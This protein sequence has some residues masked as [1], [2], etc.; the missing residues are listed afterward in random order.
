MFQA[1][2]FHLPEE[3]HMYRLIVLGAAALPL[4]VQAGLIL[5]APPQPP[6]YQVIDIDF[7]GTITDVEFGSRHV[8]ESI[9]GSMRIDLRYAPPD[10][11]S[12][13]PGAEYI[14]IPECP[15]N[16][17]PE[18]DA[19]SQFLRTAGAPLEFGGNSYDLV[20]VF[21]AQAGGS[22]DIADRFALRD[23]EIGSITEPAELLVALSAQSSVLDFVHGRGLL[24]EFDLRPADA[25]GDTAAGG[26]WR[27]YIDGVNTIFEFAIDRLRVTPKVC[28]A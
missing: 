15:R 10:R 5:E 22:V 2:H 12:Q 19:P 4:D 26:I 20:E 21:D 3:K 27:E 24:Q 13:F 25:G 6:S 8:G 28:R 1:R 11:N 9:T 14:W 7:W 23:W 16:C 17:P 18:I